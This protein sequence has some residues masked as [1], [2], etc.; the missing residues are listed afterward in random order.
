MSNPNCAAKSPCQWQIRGT[1]APS[2]SAQEAQPSYGTDVVGCQD[3]RRGY[4]HARYHNGG[5]FAAPHREAWRDAG[6][7]ALFVTDDAFQSAAAP[8]TCAKP[9]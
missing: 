9:M 2:S 4:V 7:N 8:G 5:C 3:G 6:L 1:G